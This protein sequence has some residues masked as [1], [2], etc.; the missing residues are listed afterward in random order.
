MPRFVVLLHETPPGYSRGRHYD[1]MLEQGGA[2]WTW[3]LEALPEVDGPAVPAERLADH[4]LA[5]LDYEGDI[6]GKRGHVSRIDRGTWE[7]GGGDSAGLLFCLK[8]DLLYGEL[9]L[10]PPSADSDHWLLILRRPRTDTA[11]AGAY[12]SHCDR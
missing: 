11:A 2:L 12:N 1:L 3:A 6:A 9:T 5:Y 10:S 4:R 7:A 8:G